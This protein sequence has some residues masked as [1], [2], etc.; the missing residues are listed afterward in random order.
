[1]LSYF[2]PSEVGLTI[3]HLPDLCL[4]DKGTCIFEIFSFA[5]ISINSSHQGR[6][7]KPL[8]KRYSTILDTNN[9]NQPCLVFLTCQLAREDK[10]STV[11]LN[12]VL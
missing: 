7:C 6:L 8:M 9:E 5:L 10:F 3:L 12:S 1:M 2:A 11:N 4:K